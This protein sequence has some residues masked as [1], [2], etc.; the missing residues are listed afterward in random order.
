MVFLF[1]VYQSLERG[2]RCQR[3]PWST[4]ANPTHTDGEVEEKSAG[5]GDDDSAV[6]S[7]PRHW[8]TGSFESPW[9]QLRFEMRTGAERLQTPELRHGEDEDPIWKCPKPKR[10]E[11]RYRSSEN[12][13]R[14]R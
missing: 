1:Q 3:P 6:R 11:D 4:G 2:R 14:T 13:Q 7:G 8:E 12:L 9:S 5:D 10:T